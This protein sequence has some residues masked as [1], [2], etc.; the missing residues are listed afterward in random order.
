MDEFQL[1]LLDQ[2]RTFA[3]SAIAFYIC[4]CSSLTV[5]AAWKLMLS[6]RY[7]KIHSSGTLELIQK[8]PLD[9]PSGLNTRQQVITRKLAHMETIISGPDPKIMGFL[10]RKASV[11]RIILSYGKSF[12]YVCRSINAVQNSSHGYRSVPSYCCCLS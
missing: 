12:R 8:R 6:I 9:V 3:T 7:N 4:Y 2:A 1:G 10:V 5:Q 11:F